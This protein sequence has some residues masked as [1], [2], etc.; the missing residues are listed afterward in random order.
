MINA[1]IELDE[2]I[3]DQERLSHKFCF[4]IGAATS[5]LPLSESARIGLLE[6][7]IESV[8]DLNSFGLKLKTY[9]ESRAPN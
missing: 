5:D 7:G 1:K 6:Y 8:R 2:L 4:L 9:R 3:D